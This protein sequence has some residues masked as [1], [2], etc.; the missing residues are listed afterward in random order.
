[1]SIPPGGITLMD[2][3]VVKQ[4]KL[5]MHH[6]IVIGGSMAG[7]LA[8]RVLSEH[9]ERVTIIER[10]QLL[11]DAQPRKGVPQGRH[12]HGLLAGGAAIVGEYFP[13][14]FAALAQDGAIPV[15][16][17]DIRRYQLGARVAAA[18]SPGKTLWQSRPF[19]EQHVRAALSARN[20]VHI[21]DG[22]SVTGLGVNDERITGV[23]LQHRSGEQR[24]EILS[25]DLV[26][27]ASGRGSRAP[28]WLAALGYGQVEETSVKI[29]VGYASRIYRCPEQLPTDW[30]V[31]IILGTPPDN[32]RA[33]V[34]F[35]IEGGYW[36]VTLGGW[37]RDY[38]PDDDAGFLDYA[39]SLAQPDLYEA[40]K[41][42]EPITPIAVYKYSANRWRH[43][44]RLSRLPEGF[45]IMGDA[46]CAFS[47]VYGQGMSV[48][49]LEARTLDT[50]LREQQSGTG[51]THPTNFPQRF[52]Q[53]IAKEIQ[54][55]WMLSTG[56]DW[57]YPETEGHRSVGTRLFNWYLRRVIGLT[58]SHPSMAAAFFQVWHLLKPLSSLFE[59]RIV[60]AVLSSELASRRQK[61]GVSR[62][63]EA[64][65]SP[66]P[67]R[68]L[69]EVA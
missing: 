62:S 23:L 32:K 43:Y 34:I 18:P 64:A 49:A 53:A 47:P 15:D 40:I 51:T 25:A 19:L 7:L 14:L 58:A 35:P 37:L 45:I 26:V 6:A 69:D 46:V 30:K 33:G 2:N 9:F 65:G 38:P 31:L 50:C 4:N 66:G 22:C 5:D 8:A 12:V 28:Q 29:D 52:Q 1:M 16:T 13:D 41:E 55:A 20:N 61:P 68:R 27:D 56:E 24:E 36:M 3:K 59:P 57:R 67:T 21:L 11:D 63:P 42:A 39:R 44:E 10:D 54:T 60:W 48:A 17:A